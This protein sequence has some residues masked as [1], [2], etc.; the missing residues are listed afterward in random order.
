MR[1]TSH[2]SS[3]R[4][5]IT[6]EVIEPSD[7]RYHASR[8]V[9]Y[10]EFNQ[11]QPLAIVRV[12]DASD[13]SAVIRFVGD[14]GVGLTVRAGGH[15]VLGH[16]SSDGGLVLDLTALKDLDIDLEDRSAW[17]GGGLLAGEYTDKVAEHGLVTGFGDTP[18]VGIAGLTLGGGVGF[19][20]RKYGLTIDSL[21]GAEIVTADGEVRVT[22]PLPLLAEEVQGSHP[23]PLQGGFPR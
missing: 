14:S 22:P 23:R 7:Q 1:T 18:S 11:M 2:L 9:F 12:A 16:S 15:S 10:Q 20:H 4:G 21:M 8:D 19:L 3:L 13:V 17:A 6:G 5:E